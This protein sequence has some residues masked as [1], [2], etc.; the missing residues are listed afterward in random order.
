MRC[1]APPHRPAAGLQ[2]RPHER[3]RTARG[4]AIPPSDG[5]WYPVAALL[6]RDKTTLA[7]GFASHDDDTRR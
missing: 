5:S 2:T 3:P 6:G 1:D 4:V 7:A